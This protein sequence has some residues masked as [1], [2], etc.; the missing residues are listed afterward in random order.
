MLAG[1][2]DD[3]VDVA[4]LGPAH[5][6]VIDDGA[7]RGASESEQGAKR[8][9]ELERIELNFSPPTR[10]SGCGSTHLRSSDQGQQTKPRLQTLN[11]TND[12]LLDEVVAVSSMP[13]DLA[14]VG[15]VKD[16]GL[17]ADLGVLG[18]DSAVVLVVKHGKGVACELYLKV[19]MLGLLFQAELEK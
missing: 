5:D 13:L 14:H 7:L 10:L 9:D 3:H 11:I 16:T 12:A 6:A 4:L 18:Q 2:V 1:S 17:V 8:S 15:H 19:M